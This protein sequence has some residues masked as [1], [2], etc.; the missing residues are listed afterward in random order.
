MKKWKYYYLKDLERYGSCKI[1]KRIKS[2]FKFLRKCQFTTNKLSLVLNRFV[3]K[4]IKERMNIEIYGKTNIGY[5]LYIGHPY[6]ITINENAVLGNNCNIHRGVLIG[7][8]NRGVRKGTP[9]IGNC[10]WIGVNATI[11]GKITIG[12]NV[13]IAPNSFVNCDVPSNSVVFGNPCIIKK[14]EKATNY[15]INNT[16]EE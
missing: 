8:E 4:K 6:G 12:N 7:Q 15:Y 13:L 16:A 14:K 10:V 5:G 2:F 9:T 1:D 3:F 11:V